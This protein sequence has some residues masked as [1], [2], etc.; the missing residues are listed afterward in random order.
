MKLSLDFSGASLAMSPINWVERS[1][2]SERELKPFLAAQF[3]STSIAW[4]TGQC[5][6]G[7]RRVSLARKFVAQLSSRPTWIGARA[8]PEPDVSTRANSQN[9]C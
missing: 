4:R 5:L 8:T 2:A 7:T 6:I 3:A 1:M 9:H